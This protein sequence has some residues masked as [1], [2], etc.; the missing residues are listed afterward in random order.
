MA[1]KTDTLILK[2]L[3]CKELAFRL[4]RFRTMHKIDDALKEAGWELADIETGKQKL[5]AKT[6]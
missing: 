3:E 1:K 2:L 5:G 4:N 6:Q